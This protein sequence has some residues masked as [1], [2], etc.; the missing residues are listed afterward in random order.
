MRGKKKK[1][2]RK[3]GG[4]KTTSPFVT[5]PEYGK[6]KSP[7]KL[8]KRK[9][10]QEKS[11]FVL[12]WRGCIRGE[13]DGLFRH[14]GADQDDEGRRRVSGEKGA[15]PYMKNVMNGIRVR[16][17]ISRTKRIGKEKLGKKLPKL[18]AKESPKRS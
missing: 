3:T 8:K 11:R 15:V 7:K 18:I 10:G 13:E 5:C 16:K 1:A 2:E 17:G 4:G 6:E 12:C 9:I 14:R